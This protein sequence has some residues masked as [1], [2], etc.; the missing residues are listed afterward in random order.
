MSGSFNCTFNS[1]FA[2][3]MTIIVL[4][5]IAFVGGGGYMCYASNLYHVCSDWSY[6]AQYSAHKCDYAYR[7]AGSVLFYK[8]AYPNS[9]TI[10]ECVCYAPITRQPSFPDGLPQSGNS[11]SLLIGG[12][13]MI[14]IGSLVIIG[15]SVMLIFKFK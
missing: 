2:C 15:I 13:A 5:A 9:T 1:M 10:P 4:V 8:Y 11:T 14:V 12:I 7:D 3:I 6:S